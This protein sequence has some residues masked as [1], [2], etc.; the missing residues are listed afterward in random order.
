MKGAVKRNRLKRQVR[1][2][3][4][5]QRTQFRGGLDLVVVI[6]PPQRTSTAAFDRELQQLCKRLG[7]AA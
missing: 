4:A 2:V 7:A 1:T 6:H 3:I 5:R